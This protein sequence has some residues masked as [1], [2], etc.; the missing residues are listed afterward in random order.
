MFGTA[1]AGLASSYL[2]SRDQ[3]KANAANLAQYQLSAQ[4]QQ[5]NNQQNASM[6]A[7]AL[8]HGQR[9]LKDV[10]EGYKSAQGAVSAQGVAA[11]RQIADSLRK[12]GAESRASVYG[13]GMGSS[14]AQAGLQQQAAFNTARAG[15]DVAGRMAGLRSRLFEGKAQAMSAGRARVAGILQENARGNAKDTEGMQDVLRSKVHSAERTDLTSLGALVDMG[16]SKMGDAK[17]P[18]VINEN[19]TNMGTAPPQKAYAGLAPPSQSAPSAAL[20]QLAMNQAPP[21]QKAF[22]GMAPGPQSA[23]PSEAARL[24]QAKADGFEEVDLTVKQATPPPGYKWDAKQKRY[25]P[26]DGKQNQGPKPY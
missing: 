17:A 13:R 26:I 22:A 4:E 24:E 3:K 15:S 5:Q 1:I 8:Q 21:P 2:S 12:R 20:Q 25:V 23:P 19:G 6:R 10:R 16:I 7:Q 14:S 18:D 9:G 11:N